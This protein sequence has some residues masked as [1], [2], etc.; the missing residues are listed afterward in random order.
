MN[1]DTGCG[2]T[3][4]P[5]DVGEPAGPSSGKVYK[6]ASGNLVN[7]EGSYTFKG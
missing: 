7:D 4:F 3:V 1:F 5:L 2:E 6:D